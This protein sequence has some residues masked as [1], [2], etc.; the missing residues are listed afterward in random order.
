MNDRSRT[1]VDDVGAPRERLAMTRPGRA[2]DTSAVLAREVV[3]TLAGANLDPQEF[4]HE[5]SIRIRRVVPHDASGWMTLDPDTMLPSGVL[6]TSK[7]PDLVTAL[8]RN[9]LLDADVPKMVEIAQ[10]PLPL[11]TS[12]E[13][14]PATAAESRR[15]KLI[16]SAAIGHE[17]R[18]MLRV[19]GSTWG[20]VALYRELGSRGF[21][22]DERAFLADIAEDIADGLRLS[23]TGSPDPEASALVPGVVAFDASS[24]ISSATAE[25]SRMMALMLGD[26]KTAL[27]VV[28]VGARRHGVARSRVRLADGRWLLLH[29]ARMHGDTTDVGQV[30]VT[31]MPAPRSDLTSLLLRL[32]GLSAREREVAELLMLGYA[33]DEIAARLFISRHTLHDHVKSIFAKI[34]A[35]SRSELMAIGSDH[36]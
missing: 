16:Q 20:M 10:W 1:N 31:L 19:G 12:A 33:T 13:L 11:A 3:G 27:Y 32:H 9:E 26:A 28:A 4:L 21:D 8:W 35:K 23:L 29:G 5:V 6:E 22:A 2:F 14:D 17:L 34:G 15:I 25:A 30:T 7:P 24:R 36:V 18:A